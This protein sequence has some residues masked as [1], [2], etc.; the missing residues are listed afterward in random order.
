MGL[1]PS[2]A[3]KATFGHVLTAQQTV[4]ANTPATAIAEKFADYLREN[5]LQA[6]DSRSLPGKAPTPA[7]LGRTLFG[8]AWDADTGTVRLDGIAAQIRARSAEFAQALRNRLA[9]N[10]ID[11]NQPVGLSVGAGGRIIVDNSHT[12]APAIAE[13]FAES[14]ILAQAYRDIAAQN[15]QLARM[16]VGASYVKD[17]KA[18]GNDTQRNAIWTRYSALLERLSGGFNGRMEAGPAGITA[19]SLQMIRR[20]GLA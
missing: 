6:T 18:A 2:P 9:D 11:P 14:P 13:L 3:A 19:E 5:E 12:D 20:M 1:A 7:Q 10:G 16:Q 4:A 17:W 8:K 15:D